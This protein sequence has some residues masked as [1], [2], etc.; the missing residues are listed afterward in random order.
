[1][2]VIGDAGQDAVVFEEPGFWK[3][4]GSLPA[5]DPLPDLIRYEQVAASSDVEAGHIFVQKNL[6]QPQIGPDASGFKLQ[7]KPRQ[8][9]AKKIQQAQNA[10][11]LM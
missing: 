11:H 5:K 4:A 10:S 9:L 6:V 3:R 2:I 1:M 7:K 8:S